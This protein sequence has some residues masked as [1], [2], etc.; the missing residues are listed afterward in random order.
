MEP[1]PESEAALQPPSVALSPALPDSAG[2][3]AQ[4]ALEAQFY[5]VQA[6]A[7]ASTVQPGSGEPI[8]S[9][10]ELAV[11]VGETEDAMLALSVEELE[12][13]LL[14]AER[15][16]QYRYSVQASLPLLRATAKARVTIMAEH[17]RPREEKR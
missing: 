10:A 4:L 15:A 8:A 13:L 1:E 7:T 2:E 11:A 5:E 3:R 12:Q 14:L 17:E 9:I 6:L 16:R